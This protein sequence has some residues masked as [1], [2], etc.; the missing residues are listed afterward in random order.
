MIWLG[1]FLFLFWTMQAVQIIPFIR[2][3]RLELLANGKEPSKG[4]PR[5]SIIVPARNEEMEIKSCLRSLS[6][7]DYPNLEF[8]LVDDRSTD[9]TGEIIRQFAQTDSRVRPV[10]VETLPENWL[11]KP[12][13]MHRGAEVAQGDYLLFTD[14]DVLFGPQALKR[15]LHYASECDLG[16]L[17]LIPGGISRGL[18]EKGFKML[19]LFGYLMW[20]QAGKIRS[21]SKNVYAGVGAFNLVKNSAYKNMGG[22]ETLKMEVLDDLILGRRLKQAGEKQDLLIAM[23]DLSIRWYDGLIATIQGVE[24]NMFASMGFSLIKMLGTSTIFILLYLFPYAGLFLNPDSSAWGFWLTLIVM[25]GLFAFFGR[26]LHAG[27]AITLVLPFT[28]MIELYAIWNSTFQT[29]RRGG[30]RWRECFYSLETLKTYRNTSAGKTDH[31]S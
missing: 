21:E 4:W 16:H 18:L 31:E 11:G 15:A 24:K 19:F 30:I 13:A 23:D 10:F 9:R 6:N 7:L 5:V 2:N 20:V 12:H 26:S 22:F 28:V 25:H 14:G 1:W 29:L 27:W 3:R 8:I 17:C